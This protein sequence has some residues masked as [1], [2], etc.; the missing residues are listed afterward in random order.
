MICCLVTFESDNT[1]LSVGKDVVSISL[2]IRNKSVFPLLGL[3][4]VA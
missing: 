1:K 3:K 4:L 2:F